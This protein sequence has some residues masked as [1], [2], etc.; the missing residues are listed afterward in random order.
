MAEFAYCFKYIEF[1]IFMAEKLNETDLQL[2]KETEKWLAK[3]E[4]IVNKIKPTESKYSELLKNMKAYIAD[5]KHFLEK[6]DF[7]KAFECMIWAFAIY[8]FGK[9]F[10]IINHEKLK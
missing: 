8:E 4:P 1:V 10:E 7:I 9:E 3:I 5:S 2:K 6:K